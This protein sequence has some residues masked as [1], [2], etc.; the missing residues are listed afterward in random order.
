MSKRPEI[1]V[2]DLP[3]VSCVTSDKSLILSGPVSPC[4]AEEKG[5]I[6]TSLQDGTEDQKRQWVGK[7]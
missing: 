6:I 7:G 3:S 5:T 1:Q 4:L 2:L